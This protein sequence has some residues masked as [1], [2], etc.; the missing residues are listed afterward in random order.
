MGNCGT[1]CNKTFKYKGDIIIDKLLIEQ[2]NYNCI[3]SYNLSQI[4][5]LQKNKIFFKKE[6]N[7]QIKSFK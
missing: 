5:Y 7:S 4:I 1:I 3:S 6:E 2:N